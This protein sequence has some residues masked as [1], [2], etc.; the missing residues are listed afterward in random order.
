MT[1]DLNNHY[2]YPIKVGN[3]GLVNSLAFDGIPFTDP[4]FDET[5]QKAR[6]WSSYNGIPP[7]L[8]HPSVFINRTKALNHV[9]PTAFIFHISRCGSTLLSQLLATVPDTISLAEVPILDQSLKQLHLSPTLE[10]KKALFQAIMSCYGQQRAQENKLF[11]KLDSWHLL[12][13]TDLRTIYPS[14]PFLIMLRSPKRVWAS[15]LHRAGIQSVHGLIGQEFLPFDLNQVGYHQYFP[16]LLNLF[17]QRAL[18]FEKTDHCTRLLLYEHGYTSWLDA[19][20][21]SCQTVITDSDRELM[22]IRSK[23][24]AK[25]NQT[26]FQERTLPNDFPASIES[27]EKKYREQLLTNRS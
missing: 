22:K 24:H 26:V 12:F 11:I 5:V 6:T 9:A 13:L 8:E 27:L 7:L 25:D 2:Y 18:S 17:F 14:V 19:I 15:N 23:T 16:K 3:D 1:N 21:T 10:D 4:F 20:E